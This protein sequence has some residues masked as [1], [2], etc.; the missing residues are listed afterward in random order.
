MN[1]GPD[2]STLA[3]SARTRFTRASVALALVA[4]SVLAGAATPVPAP[5]LDRLIGTALVASP[6]LS[7]R[8]N[9][10]VAARSDIDAARWQ[11]TPQASADVQQGSGPGALN[12]RVIRVDQRLYAGGRLDADLS[13]ARSRRDSAVYAVQESALAL[14]V[15]IASAYQGLAA[16]NTQLVAIDAYRRRL[17]ALDGTISRRIE[18][19]V[20]ASADRSL[21]SARLA[22]SANDLATVRATRRNALA[23]L[24]KLVGNP[25]VVGA[26]A[27]QAV[28]VSNGT[29][30]LAPVCGEDG[31]ADAQLRNA[32]A[33]HPGL[34]RMERDIDAARSQVDSQRATTRPTVGLR[35]EQPVAPGSD[36]VLRSTRV[37]IV[38]QY[39]PDA[40]L[41]SVARTQGANERVASLVNQADAMRRDVTQQIRAECAE[42]SGV[43]ER[44]AGFALA[45]GYTTE[46]LASSTR[47]FVAG[48]RSWLDLLNAA[49]EDFDN[50]QAGITAGAALIGS[51]YRLALL[52][53]ERPL[54]LP[55]VA[56]EPASNLTTT[57]K[58]LFR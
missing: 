17:D 7:A 22:Q 11:Y 42:Q 15:Q 24:D 34:Q 23:T 43:V 14:A 3:A 6:V 19:G 48:K 47:L 37:S 1:D 27:P 9:E 31:A 44:I 45:R 40:G 16:A 2:N 20:S 51:S 33:V 55:G 5:L 49:R 13:S 8:R 29:A 46:V 18:S 32:L 36:A 4:N 52:T 26:V 39:A 28:V 41:S 53:G 35:L 57:V 50:E 30:T 56:D 10:V 25:E 58:A 21:M 12:G 38:L 54:D